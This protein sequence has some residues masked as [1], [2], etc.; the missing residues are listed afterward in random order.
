[1]LEIYECIAQDRPDA[2][3]RFIER[4]EGTCQWLATEREMGQRADGLRHGARIFSHEKYV[5]FYEIVA[6]DIRVLRIV[7]GARD[8]GLLF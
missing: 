6:N 4:L 3:L 8:Y 2:A 7:H 1:L 5:I